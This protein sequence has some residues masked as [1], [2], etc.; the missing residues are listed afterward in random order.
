MPA[1]II[2]YTLVLCYLCTSYGLRDVRHDSPK[3]QWGEEHATG[4]GPADWFT[5]PHGSAGAG[6]GELSCR[7]G[8]LALSS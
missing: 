1:G 8:Q 5:D 3:I 6:K 2:L 7:R 4:T